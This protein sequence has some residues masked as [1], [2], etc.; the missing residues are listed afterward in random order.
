M[1]SVR[2]CTLSC[3]ALALLSCASPYQVV[4]LPE[5]EADLYPLSQTRAQITIAIDE[6]TNTERGRRYFG[7]D[8]LR[9]G[10]VPFLVVVSNYGT[11]RVIVR[12][13]DILAHRGAEIV[14]PV[15]IETVIAIATNE[16]PFLHSRTQAQVENYFRELAFRE[17]V[18]MHAETYQGVIFVPAPRHR[19]SS[20]T[21]FTM[22]NLFSESW[23]KVDVAVRDLDADNRL[24]FGPFS[25]PAVEN[26]SD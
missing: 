7:A 11:H 10:I 22:L 17:T 23:L 8:L 24:R 20:D 19:S 5:R 13:A 18:L 6:I 21:L 26:S 15:P 4:K 16:R 14:D 3:L 9:E 1:R 2:T 12:P 25:L